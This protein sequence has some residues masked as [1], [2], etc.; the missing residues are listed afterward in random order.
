MNVSPRPR[1]G[2]IMPPRGS[3]VMPKSRLRRYSVSFRPI[4][5]GVVIR[6]SLGRLAPRTRR[7]GRPLASDRLL[8]ART[9]LPLIQAL[10]EPGH[11]VHDRRRFRLRRLRHFNLL[12]LQLRLDDA[13]Q[14]RPIVVL[15]LRCVER[16]RQIADELLG[17]LQLLRAYRIGLRKRIGV[18]VYYLIAEAHDLEAQGI[19]DHFD[20]AEMM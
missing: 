11:Q 13:H 17:H 2:T 4:V 15:V 8:A 5:A 20:T 3:A 18:S 9:G 16:L 1:R 12:P 10:L 6:S 7:A 19:A 14:I